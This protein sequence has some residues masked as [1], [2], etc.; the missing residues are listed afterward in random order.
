MSLK[1]QH[2]RESIF[3]FS[4]KCSSKAFTEAL[5]RGS[6]RGSELS[7]NRGK[8]D[9]ALGWFPA[10]VWDSSEVKIWGQGCRAGM[11]GRDAGYSGASS[12]RVT[13]HFG[14]S[15]SLLQQGW[16]RI[17]RRN[18]AWTWAQKQTD[19]QEQTP[20]S[21]RGRLSRGLFFTQKWAVS[22]KSDSYRTNLSLSL[23][24]YIFLIVSH[25]PQICFVPSDISALS[26]T[27][28]WRDLVPMQSNHQVFRTQIH[29][30]NVSAGEFPTGEI[31]AIQT[32]GTKKIP[33]PQTRCWVYLFFSSIIWFIHLT[34]L[35]RSL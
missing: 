10:F 35:R 5:A 9:E 28:E 18:S 19:L 32:A 8:I 31:E 21:A 33:V 26:F 14:L 22:V 13:T 11:R 2:L 25:F 23:F 29:N 6:A 16:W 1:T 27:D 15:N 7:R 30:R 4:L 17:P 24:I 34:V 12:S 20:A 3:Q